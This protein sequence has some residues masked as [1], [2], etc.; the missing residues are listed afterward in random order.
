[1]ISKINTEDEIRP[2]VLPREDLV[3]WGICQELLIVCP[4]A[5]R[6]EA[7]SREE[8]LALAGRQDGDADSQTS[9]ELE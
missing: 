6:R 8:I 3:A 9:A 5:G 4:A 2:L 1:M 7:F